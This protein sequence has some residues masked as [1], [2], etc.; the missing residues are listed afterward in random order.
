MKALSVEDIDTAAG[1]HSRPECSVPAR[2]EQRDLMPIGVNQAF[3]TPACRI[4]EERA[5]KAILLI[6]HESDA[7]VGQR[8]DAVRVNR[9]GADAR[10]QSMPPP[11]SSVEF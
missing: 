5:I 2:H 7:A 11:G 10:G 8:H 3:E 6:Y 9:V 1:R 4:E